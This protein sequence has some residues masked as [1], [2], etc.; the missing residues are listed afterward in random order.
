MLNRNA[1]TH[2]QSFEVE[3]VHGLEQLFLYVVLTV[4]VG[5]DPGRLVL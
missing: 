5:V 3:P 4:R 1:F 2:E